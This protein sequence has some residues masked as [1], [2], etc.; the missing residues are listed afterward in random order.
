MPHPMF[1]IS[2]EGKPSLWIRPT[3]IDFIQLVREV[4]GEDYS[5]NK[6]ESWH[7]LI[8]H[9]SGSCSIT[10]DTRD[11]AQDACDQIIDSIELCESEKT[12]DS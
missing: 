9:R 7:L 4:N 1:Q 2:F 11:D 3:A 5:G 8:H 6:E 10:F 12:K